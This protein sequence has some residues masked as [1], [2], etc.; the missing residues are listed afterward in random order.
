MS[1]LIAKQVETELLSDTT[2]SVTVTD[3]SLELYQ[4]I[5]TTTIPDVSILLD[6]DTTSSV[7]VTD[8][9]LELYQIIST[10]T[11][12]DVSILLDSLLIDEQKV[13]TLI[14]EHKNHFT[15]EEWKKIVWFENHF[16]K[17]VEHNLHQLSYEDV[18]QL[19]FSKFQSFLSFADCNKTWLKASSQQINEKLTR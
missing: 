19:K 6:S 4:I 16:S 15:A 2:S 14:A 10:T 13:P 12:P 8:S 7:T 11:I 18:L 17:T 5:S 9:S 3:S 1:P